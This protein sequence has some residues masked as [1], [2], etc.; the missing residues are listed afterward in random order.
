MNYSDNLRTALRNK[1]ITQEGLAKA[2]NKSTATINRKI[3][4][5]SFNV[6]E[7]HYIDSILQV[8][9]LNELLELVM[10]QRECIKQKGAMD[11]NLEHLFEKQLKMITALIKI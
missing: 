9:D 1:G 6:E 4:A 11:E 7:K 8:D 3:N 2:M 5:N 10:L